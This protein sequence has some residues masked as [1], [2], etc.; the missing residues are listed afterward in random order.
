[1]TMSSIEAPVL[2]ARGMSAGYG[3]LAAVREIDVHVNA[4]EVV[5]LLGPNGAGKTTTI[6]TLAGEL[7]PLGGEVLWR[8]AVA[9]PGL[10]RRTRSGL[11]LV[12]EERSVFTDLTV[13]ENLNIGLGPPEAAV[14]LFPELRPH[15]KRRA[16]LLSGGQQ[17]ML[18]LARALAARPHALLIDEL[19]LGLAPVLVERLIESVRASARR[20]IGVLLVEQ[21]VRRALAV[22]DRAYV[23]RR[24][25]IV[26]EGDA[27]ELANRTD[28]IE[29]MY[30]D[31]PSPPTEP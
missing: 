3:S 17:Q 7:A 22:A 15:L 19:S 2:E 11:G 6:L 14:E 28:E 24:G 31:A 5:A 16:G 9:R 13:A 23:L 1:M 26:L 20:G 18:T 21:H 10:A 25:R 30:L 29:A 4:G 8:G 27:E 12:L